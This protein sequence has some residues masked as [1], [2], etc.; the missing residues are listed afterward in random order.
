MVDGQAASLSS[1]EVAVLSVLSDAAPEPVSEEDLL[2][3]AWGYRTTKTRTVSMGISRLRAKVEQDPKSPQVVLTV[4]GHGYRLVLA[5]PD[6][7]SR[8]TPTQVPL[9]GR[10]QE[11]QQVLDALLSGQPAE[12]I[13][14]GG[15]GTTTLAR[16]VAGEDAHWVSL[17]DVRRPEGLTRRLC[18]AL[19]LEGADGPTVVRKALRTAGPIVLDAAESLDDDAVALLRSFAADADGPVV[20]TS[21]RPLD[22][23]RRVMVGPLSDEASLAV[24]QQARRDAGLPLLELS[25]ARLVLDEAGGFPLGLTLAAPLAELAAEGMP[26]GLS[27]DPDGAL[28][29]VLRETLALC[30]EEGRRLLAL[31]SS[32]A[33][34]AG[35]DALTSLADAS[36]VDVLRTLH[37]LRE[38]GLVN[39]QQ[40]V[41][42]VPAAVAAVAITPDARQQHARWAAALLTDPVVL[43][44]MRHELEAALPWAD[45]DT[46]AHLLMRH[47]VLLHVY[48]P[49]GRLDE[50]VVGLLHRVA[51]PG[52]RH[53]VLGAVLQS[54]QEYEAS[55]DSYQ[56]ALD[57][58]PADDAEFRGWAWLQIS[59]LA[60]WLHRN[61][62]AIGSVEPMLAVREGVTDRALWCSLTINAASL[63]A[64]H[65]PDRAT[66]LFRQVD[67]Y[68]DEAP[69]LALLAAFH[70]LY[71]QRPT[72]ADVR[73][74]EKQL[75]AVGIERLGPMRWHAHGLRVGN[76]WLRAGDS[77]RGK[78]TL[79]A[80]IEQ[81]LALDPRAANNTLVLAAAGQLHHPA[82]ARELFELLPDRSGPLAESVGWYLDGAEGAPPTEDASLLRVWDQFVTGRPVDV[83]R[84][85]VGLARALVHTQT[86]AKQG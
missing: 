39:L 19:G 55:Y 29:T 71:V 67:P 6:P 68:A 84:P 56:K 13:G 35:L 41:V 75:D 17:R 78:K 44:P 81:T 5:T 50:E 47:I 83:V 16:E 8:P 66:D 85:W 18:G 64:V 76:A 37:G 49:T 62:T 46:L 34:P 48:G 28:V 24:L 63:V 30:S 79:L 54:T 53:V 59:V 1:I 7:A 57:E 21:R 25:Q 26:L 10:E 32:F 61:D 27:T 11:Q 36:R 40:G 22:V 60:T 52:R 70:R 38:R 33:V 58:L 2:R 80:H 15:V 65:A 3:E 20:L 74:V 4:R 43:R 42:D 82:L 73:W 69:S 51:S 86:L 23:G 9:L 12:L 14:P 72:T 31:A 77:V 45:G